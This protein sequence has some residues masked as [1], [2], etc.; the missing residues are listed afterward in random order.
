MEQ[1]SKD[2]AEHAAE[3][4][5]AVKG[6]WPLVA[7]AGS[8]AVVSALHQLKRGYKQ[9]TFGQRII[10][11][12]VNATLTASLAVSCALL[13]PLAVPDMTLEMQIAV[14]VILSGLGGETVKQWLLH[15]LGLH[16]VDLMNPS[17]INDIR[18]T[19]DPETRRRHVAQ[20]PFKNDECCSC[21]K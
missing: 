6:T 9:R 1:F 19:M 3:Y 12:L 13:M 10:T 2:S 18:Q 4:I 16:V 15:K 8:V 17:D 7:L 20:C 11:V 21:K 5:G 14:A